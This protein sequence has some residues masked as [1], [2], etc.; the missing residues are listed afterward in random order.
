M[1]T[2]VG[3]CHKGV[4][5]LNDKIRKTNIGSNHKDIIIHLD[6]NSFCLHRTFKQKKS[7]HLQIKCQK[8]GVLFITMIKF[9]TEKQTLEVTTYV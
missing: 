2:C 6:C 3:G 7:T 1:Y 4:K 5:L 8:L 9:E